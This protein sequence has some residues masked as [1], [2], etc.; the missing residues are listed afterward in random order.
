MANVSVSQSW[1]DEMSRERQDM[2]RKL[3]WQTDEVARLREALKPFA[4][5]ARDCVTRA[6]EQNFGDGYVISRGC[7]TEGLTVGDLRSVLKALEG[8]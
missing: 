8:A 2:L 1:I 6:D 5:Y 3:E 7:R 4:A